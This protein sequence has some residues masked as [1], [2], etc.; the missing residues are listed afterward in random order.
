MQ[1]MTAMD[2]S[3]ISSEDKLRGKKIGQSGMPNQTIRF[4]RR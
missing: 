4:P 2:T 1:E 3:A